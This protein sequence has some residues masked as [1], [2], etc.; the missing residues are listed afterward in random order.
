MG[1]NVAPNGFDCN[2]EGN[3]GATSQLLDSIVRG[4]A[5]EPYVM[6]WAAGNERGSGRCG[7]LYNTTAPPAGAKNPIQVGATN[8]DTDT[9]RKLQQLGTNR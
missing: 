6:T 8:S 9:D 1:T 3:Y 2:L 4:S 7:T 5:G